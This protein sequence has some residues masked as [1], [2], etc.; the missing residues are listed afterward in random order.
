MEESRCF[1]ESKGKKN[2]GRTTV[3]W[4]DLSAQC[5]EVEA[6]EQ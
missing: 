4:E 5:A 2:R 3:I 1:F 6:P